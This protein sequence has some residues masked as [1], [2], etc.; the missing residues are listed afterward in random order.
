MI[1]HKKI[2]IAKKKKVEM[3]TT[4][5]RVANAETVLWPSSIRLI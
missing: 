3:R 5:W 1:L 4:R 2:G